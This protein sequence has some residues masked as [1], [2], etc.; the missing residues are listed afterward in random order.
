[1]RKLAKLQIATIG[2]LLLHCPFRY[3][4]RSHLTPIK[5]VLPDRAC[6]IQGKILHS[7]ADIARKKK[8]CV[9]TLSDEQGGIM[10]VVFFHYLAQKTW[11][12]GTILRCYG[13]AKRVGTLMQM[14]H[15]EV[16][17]IKDTMTTLP[18]HLTAVYPT[19]AGLSQGWLRKTIDK[20]LRT[21]QERFQNQTDIFAN[22]LKE[23]VN[24]HNW[25][26]ALT[27]V[28]QPSNDN[29]IEALTSKKH[30]AFTR[31]I[32]EELF[33]HH[34][35]LLR[36]KQQ[37]KAQLACALPHNESIHRSF[38]EKLP[39]KLTC[40][41]LKAW[42][43]IANDLA[44][45]TPMM[46]LVQG[47]V[48]CGKTIVAALS[49]L[50]AITSGAQV[51][52]MAPTEILAEQHLAHFTEWFSALGYRCELLVSKLKAK[53]KRS[54]KENITLGLTHVIIGTH[55]LFQED[56]QFNRVGLVIIDEQHRFGVHQR[57]ALQTKGLSAKYSSHPHQLIMTATPIPRT[58]A[59]SQY[60]H[61]DISVIDSLPPGRQAITTLTIPQTRR[62]E[63][64]E[65]MRSVCQKGQQIYWVCALIE[66]SEILTCQAAE[67]AAMLLQSALP[68][69]RVGLVHG[70]ME[71]DEKEAV[72][73]AF[74][75]NDIAILVATTVIEVGVNVPNATLMVIENPER[76]GLAQLHQLRGRVGRG[77]DASY[78]ILLYGNLSKMA[79]E[80]L[81]ILRE[82]TDG[83][84]IA[85]ADLALRGP[86]EILGTRQTGAVSFK[87]A[88]LQ[89]DEELL[90]KIAE[91][92]PTL[93][94]P[95][96]HV[97]R[98]I[99]KWL[100]VHDYAKA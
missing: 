12:N 69:F 97:E 98:L 15:P 91:H 7:K 92:A 36:L 45:E 26:D 24:M 33:A 70:R 43:E 46:R 47:D 39:F 22:H 71:S 99:A 58:L 73:Q 49:A 74:Y 21:Y 65:R 34:A 85:E 17:F 42:H 93:P 76:F 16:E 66:E 53:E 40:A 55:A 8:R 52:I 19:V 9:I 4:D 25:V 50:Q 41:Q 75:R 11:E 35:S 94:I 28:H 87:V 32:M 44:K 5:D 82:T 3:E 88:D 27:T 18:E 86:G 60:S 37:T 83:F 6:V 96:H 59:M 95:S 30:P 20:L 38:V 31:L 67:D 56:I 80:R 63:M 23:I 57:L 51:A 48:G 77:L 10:Q 81:R 72:M 64:I 90:E 84:V 54:I 13:Q 100:G 79:Q 78:C 1:G 2:D 89:R 62:D 14:V 68:E 29:D 61:L